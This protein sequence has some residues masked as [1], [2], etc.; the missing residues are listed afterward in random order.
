MMESIFFILIGV[1]FGFA[2]KKLERIEVGVEIM[3]DRIIELERHIPKRKN[4]CFLAGEN[5]DFD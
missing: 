2:L 3:K 4:D 1:L 5:R